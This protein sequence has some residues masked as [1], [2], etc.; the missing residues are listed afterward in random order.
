MAFVL[1]PRRAF[2]PLILNLLLLP[3]LGCAT[4]R[5]VGPAPVWV[6][7]LGGPRTVV[8]EPFFESTEWQVSYRTERAEVFGGFGRPQ[9]VMVNREVAQKPVF[10]RVATLAAEQ[11]AVLLEIAR[12]RPRWRVLS[13]GALTAVEGPVTVVRTV[14]GEAEVVGTNRA[15]KSMALG[16]GILIPPLLL[17]NIEP[18]HE[19]QRVHG[20][21]TRY[22]GEG[23]E[24]RRRLLRYPTQPDFAIDTRGLP[25]HEQSFGLDLEFEEGV[26]ASDEKRDPVLVGEFTRRLAAAIIA[27]VEEVPNG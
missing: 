27:L 15:L 22:R 9:E 19:L 5:I 23:V 14:V 6:P 26:L 13:P 18:V 20:T 17:L 25:A 12:Q 1:P 21:V 3:L 2:H 4:A 16:F 11:R 7:E 24:L 8:I 10:A